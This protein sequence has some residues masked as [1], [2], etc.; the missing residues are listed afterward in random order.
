[1][2]HPASPRAVAPN[3][4]FMGQLGF[5]LL[6]LT[7]STTPGQ[8]TEQEIKVEFE[9]TLGGMVEAMT[10]IQGRADSMME[11]IKAR[12]EL[13]REL[14]RELEQTV[15]EVEG[16]QQMLARMELEKMGLQ[17]ETMRL[18][19]DRRDAEARINTIDR[20][21]QERDKKMRVE[22]KRL[23]K[24][25]EEVATED[26]KLKKIKKQMVERMA[27]RDRLERQV[28]ERKEEVAV[29]ELKLSNMTSLREEAEAS[30]PF[31]A[32]QPIL[33]PA[34]GIS[35][36]LNMVTAVSLGAAIISPVPSP[37]AKRR[38]D[39]PDRLEGRPPAPS[40]P[41]PGWHELLPKEEQSLLWQAEDSKE[42]EAWHQQV[43]EEQQDIIWQQPKSTVWPDQNDEGEG[44]QGGY[45]PLTVQA[46]MVVG[47]SDENGFRQFL[48]DEIAGLRPEE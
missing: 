45:G 7:S 27:E 33:L 16:V 22:E 40:V 32:V 24:V 21:M 25:K 44:W 17:E 30:S 8:A 26:D 9:E 1:M 20:L 35:V 34:F 13:L 12:E 23:T 37:A 47:A 41:P 38:A 28:K 10:E 6:L 48:E 3:I 31:R 2:G 19:L 42:E 46:G 5:L 36:L 43:E 11:E 4:M 39:Q 18:K 15:G 14:G 29:A